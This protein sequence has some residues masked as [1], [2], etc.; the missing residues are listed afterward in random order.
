MDAAFWKSRYEEGTTNWD[1]GTVSPPLKAYFDQLENKSISILIPGCG[2]GHE[3]LYLAQNDFSAVTVVDLI[4]DPLQKI[5]AI[6]PSVNTVC[7]DFFHFMGQFDCIIEQTLFCAIDPL[8]RKAY[9][10]KAYD[11]LKPGGKL[12]GVLF[13]REFEGGPPFGGNSEEYFSLFKEIFQEVTLAP[14]Y[15]SVGPRQ[16]SEVFIQA[17]RLF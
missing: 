8:M 12:V 13:N 17:K 1:I 16:G 5:K 15:N 3:A 7:G 4:D 9:V 6:A 11:L 14:C 10:Q 2:F